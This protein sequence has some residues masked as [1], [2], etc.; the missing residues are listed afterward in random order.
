MPRG[1]PKVGL[2]D[3]T[4]DQPK[5]M[6]AQD[7]EPLKAQVA[8]LEAQLTP[9]ESKGFYTPPVQDP[10]AVR[11]QIEHKKMLLQQDDDLAARGSEKDRLFA[12]KKEI[13]G[14]L[15]AHKPT[16]KEM[17]QMPTGSNSSAFSRAVDHNVKYQEKYQNLEHE[18]QDLNI[19]LEPEDPNAQSLEYLRSDVSDGVVTV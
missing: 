12:R 16:A 19:R 5:K 2:Q 15:A 13:E 11:K 1:R 8:E 6:S 17:S 7:R 9:Q 18:L 14:I 3:P 4:K 10:A